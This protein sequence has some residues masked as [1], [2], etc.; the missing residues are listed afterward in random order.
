MPTVMISMAVYANLYL[1][2]ADGPLCPPAVTDAEKCK[3]TW[4]VLLL[5]FMNVVRQ[6]TQVNYHSHVYSV[7]HCIVVPLSYSVCAFVAHMK[8]V[9][10][11]SLP[12]VFTVAYITII[13]KYGRY[14]LNCIVN[15]M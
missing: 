11:F 7:R 3:E 4:W 8:K 6:D 15:Y 14:I 1:Y 5:M 12:L 2:I 10:L 9:A 13:A